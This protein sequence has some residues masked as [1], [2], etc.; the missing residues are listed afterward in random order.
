[1]IRNIPLDELESLLNELRING[2]SYLGCVK[3]V[4]DKYDLPLLEA[5]DLVLNS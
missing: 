2:K 3:T 1:M 4:K 5:V